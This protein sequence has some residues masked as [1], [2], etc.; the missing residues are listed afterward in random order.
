MYPIIESA[1]NLT[2]DLEKQQARFIV[3]IDTQTGTTF[4][5]RLM[6]D[7]LQEYETTVDGRGALSNPLEGRRVNLVVTPPLV[8][9]G[10]ELAE[11]YDEMTVVVKGKVLAR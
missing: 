10:N 11:N 2:L 9:Y 7:V 5:S 3:D 8:K 6:D 1:V 4:N